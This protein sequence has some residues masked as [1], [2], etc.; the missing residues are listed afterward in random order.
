MSG[1]DRPAA[2]GKKLA[3]QQ[4]VNQAV[5]Q[6]CDIMRRSNCAGALQYVPELTWILF[7][8]ILDER[9]EQEAAEARAVGIEY[10]PSLEAPYRWRDWAAPEGSE[11]ARLQSGALGAVFHFLNEELL[12]YLRELGEQPGATSRQKVISQIMSGVEHTRIDTERNFLDVIDKVDEIDH[13]AV[14]TTHVFTL[15]QVYEGL[16]LKM[17]EK[18]ND[19]GQFFTP[20]EIIRAMVRVVDPRIGETVYDPGCGTGGFL[21]Q[22]F[23]QMTGAG[24]GNITSAEQL[25]TLQEHTFYGREKDN[26]IYPI[27]LANLVLHGIDAPHVW[28]GNTLT[29]TV[30]YDG[31]FEGAP[32][33]YDVILMN[34]PFGGKEGK[35]AQTR[36]AY[37]TGATQV[38]FL[39]HV[40][41][42]LRPPRGR[43]DGGTSSHGP[44]GGGVGG[45]CG[46]VID[47][48]VLFRT[49]E[50]AFVQSKRKLLDD[51]DL[52][53]IVSMP[54][55][56]FSQAG[57]GVKTNL[58]FFNK[59][60]PTERVWYYDLSDLKVGKKTPFTLDRMGDF[61]ELVGDCRAGGFVE[62]PDSERSWTVTREE[63]E[64]RNYDLK[65]VNPHRVVEEDTRTP[66]ELLDLIEEQQRVIADAIK[67]LRGLT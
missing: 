37:K 30:A 12:P 2:G 50:S 34:P 35:E 43:S 26:A 7:L 15:S 1:S 31:L 6:I 45:R 3:T 42:S 5:K 38:L 60:R 47:E 18:G 59:G 28:H 27:A 48:G 55:G 20:R 46:M 21:A 13:T 61:F 49:N 66:E 56:V 16:L 14:E 57:A 41:D 63:I 33:L 4:S 19:G 25:V 24:N 23:E 51:C 67:E 64:A 58:L 40:I 53:C 9:E 65:A 36:F 39:Q 54:P 11:R 10:K 29:G 32:P 22:S 62:R 17:G 8:R 44:A 52:W